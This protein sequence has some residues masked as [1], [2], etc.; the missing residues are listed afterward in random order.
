M[1]RTFFA[2]SSSS[3]S[4]LSCVFFS[5]WNTFWSKTKTNLIPFQG[6]TP[7]VKKHISWW[8]LRC[9]WLNNSFQRRTCVQSSIFMLETNI[10]QIFGRNNKT[11]DVFGTAALREGYMPNLRVAR[12]SGLAPHQKV[13]V[14]FLQT[15]SGCF[16]CG[17]FIQ[18]FCPPKNCSKNLGVAIV[19][20]MLQKSCSSWGW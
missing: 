9:R 11:Q 15:W 20:L 8:W 13:D 3:L 14:Y 18:D 4:S 1:P 6:E 5:R 12:G 17:I 2:S 10:S 19:L 16:F 7:H